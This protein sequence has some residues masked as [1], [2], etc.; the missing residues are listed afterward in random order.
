[1]APVSMLVFAPFGNDVK[2]AGPLLRGFRLK[3]CPQCGAVDPPMHDT[4]RR[5][6]AVGLK[7]V[8]PGAPA[9]GAGDVRQQDEVELLL[10][11]Y[12]CRECGTVTTVAPDSLVRGGS[13][14]AALRDLVAEEYLSGRAT[15]EQLAAQV[16]CS[17]STCWRWMRH[18]TQRAADWL[19]ACRECL[20]G[21]GEAVG[22][23][24]PPEAKRGLWQRRRIRAPGMLEGLLV[25]E[26]L[27][28]WMARL[29]AAWRQRERALPR[30][31]WAFG[32][33]I[34]EPLC[35]PPQAER[36]RPP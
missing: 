2:Q 11:R 5:V 27:G 35:R 17:K 7:P 29:R 6:V 1:M 12:I 34:L 31:L 3:A 19:Q 21:E 24:V 13:Y 8:P 16:G 22:P 33:H 25:A 28:Q 26:V 20:A 23:V 36:Q 18:L 14:P 32:C 15:Y 9:P 10:W 4:R 30:G